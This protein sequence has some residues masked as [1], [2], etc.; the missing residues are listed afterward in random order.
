[1]DRLLRAATWHVSKRIWDDDAVIL[2]GG[3][4]DWQSRLA[5]S[6]ETRERGGSGVDQPV[7]GGRGSGGH[8]C[9]EAA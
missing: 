1:M 6:F 4:A 5:G 2:L 3:T 9:W 7:R 8:P